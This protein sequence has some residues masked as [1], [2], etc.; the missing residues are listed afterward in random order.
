MVARATPARRCNTASSMATREPSRPEV[1]RRGCAVLDLS[2]R[3]W[4]SAS[5]G[6]RPSTVTL[7]HVPATGTGVRE[8]NR[9]DGSE[10]ERI[11]FSS[12]SKHPTSSVGPN[13]FFTARKRRMRECLSP[14]N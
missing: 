7:R 10:T 3:A 1:A 12:R 4:T 6:L 8:T 13:R 2:S 9:P 14:S 11:P 5:S